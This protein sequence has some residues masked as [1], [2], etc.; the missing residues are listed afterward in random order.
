MLVAVAIFVV[1]SFASPYFLD[2]WSL[3]DLTFNFTEKAT[4]RAGHGAADHLRRDRPVGRR[5]H[6]AGLD[7]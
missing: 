3:S 1:N 7:R 5:H 4:D 2:A 6:R